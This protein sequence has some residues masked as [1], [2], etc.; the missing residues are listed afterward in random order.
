MAP[1]NP[2][3]RQGDE[4]ETQDSITSL[5]KLLL[6]VRGPKKQELAELLDLS[7]SS[8]SQRLGGDGVRRRPWRTHEVKRLAIFYEIST[9]ALLGDERARE[10]VLDELKEIAARTIE[11]R[12]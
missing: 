8:L 3:E 2:L 6:E 1:K 11:D 5:V 7:A 10:E 4:Q 9:D 12:A